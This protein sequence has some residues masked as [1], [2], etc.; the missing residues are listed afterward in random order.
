MHTV[1]NAK[2][3][4]DHDNGDDNGKHRSLDD[5]G[6]IHFG[7]HCLVDGKHRSVDRIVN[8]RGDVYFGKHRSVNCFVNDRGDVHIGEHSFVDNGSY[9]HI[10]KHCIFDGRDIGKH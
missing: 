6:D 4:A 1:A 10:G 8:D 5:R 2:A 9:V 3:D 7:E